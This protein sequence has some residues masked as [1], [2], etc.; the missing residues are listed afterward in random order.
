M[1]DTPP[2]RLK[3]AEINSPRYLEEFIEVE[4]IASGSF[5]TV[6]IARNRLDGMLY[7]IKVTRHQIY[8]NTHKEK[9]ALNEVFAHAALINHKHVVRYHNSWVENGRVY[10]QNEYCEG[11]SLACKIQELKNSGQCFSEPELKRILLHIAKGLQYIHAKKL[12]HLDIKPE[13]ILISLDDTMNSPLRKEFEAELGL[14]NHSSSNAASAVTPGGEANASKTKGGLF[15]G[16]DST[17]SGNH[18]GSNRNVR[19]TENSLSR[20]S[21]SSGSP[22]DERLS[23]KIG[24][25]GHVSQIHGGP[26]P[27]EGDCRY[28]AP[29]LLAMDINREL[30]TKSDIFSLGLTLF[31]AASL[32]ELPKNSIEDP[33]YENLKAGQI[34]YLE[35]YSKDFNALLKVCNKQIEK[36]D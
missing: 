36:N 7:A 34:P 9:V 2:K 13:N 21:S 5:G 14:E 24:D 3:I 10:I 12:V 28:M 20:S 32:K 33:E 19:K 25:L 26:V 30:L 31:E 22:L 35:N 16:N 6:K 29:E 11:G 1:E 23:F 18:S 15:S 8:G 4:E 17:D 27:E